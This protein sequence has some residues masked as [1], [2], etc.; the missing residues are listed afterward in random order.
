MSA[1]EEDAYPSSFI[2][3]GRTVSIVGNVSIPLVGG[4]PVDVLVAVPWGFA[5][6]ACTGRALAL[7]PRTGICSGKFLSELALDEGGCDTVYLLPFW[8]AYAAD[9]VPFSSFVASV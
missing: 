2:S 6:S 3:E 9:P 5:G 8:D 7:D 4:V 1:R